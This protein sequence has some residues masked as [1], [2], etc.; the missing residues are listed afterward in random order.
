[1]YKQV[2][3]ILL[4]ILV[5]ALLQ[6]PGSAQSFTASN[7][8]RIGGWPFG[9]AEA[10][11]LDRD[12]DLAFLGSGGAVLVLDVADPK[13][14]KL[15][16]DEIRTA[17][18]V[19]DVHF[20]VLTRRLYIAAGEGGLEIWDLQ[21]PASPQRQSATEVLYFNVE[22]P[23][24]RV[25][26]EGQFA[27][28]ACAWGYVH[29]LDVSDPTNPINKGFSG[30]GGNPTIDLYVD[31]GYA[32]AAGPY[33]QRFKIM[34]DGSLNSA[35]SRHYSP[36]CSS[37][38]AVG[39][40]AY[41][42]YGGY[43]DILD[44]NALYFS[45]FSQV[46]TG[47]VANVRVV[48]NLAYVA[49]GKELLI[50]DVTSPANPVQVGYLDII[51][52]ALQIAIDGD[53]AYIAAG[54]SGLRVIDIG[55]PAVPFEAGNYE[56][57]SVTW[58][59]FVEGTYAYLAEGYEGL[60]IVDLADPEAAFVVGQYDSHGET[61]DVVLAEN[62]AYLADWDGGFRIVDVTTPA[63]P[64]ELGFLS[65]LNVWRVAVDDD[66]AYIIEGIVN[67]IY[68][69]RVID[70]TNPANPMV[71]GTLPL[72]SEVVWE[73]ALSGHHA[74]IA[75][76]NDGLRIV[77]ISDPT[78]P[79][80][81]G[82]Y[83]ANSVLD[84]CVRDDLAYVA[85]TD[86]VGGFLILDVSDPA[87]PVLK[88]KYNPNGWFHPFH[89]AV[90]GNYAYV[91]R[92]EE[93]FLFDISDPANI[94][95]IDV[96]TVPLDISRITASGPLVYLSDFWAGLQLYENLLLEGALEADV[97]EL[98]A[99]AGGESRFTLSAG[100]A[101]ANRGY[102]LL[103]SVSGTVPGTP[104]PGGAATLPL[105][106]DLFTGLVLALG[107]TSSFVDFQGNLD[108]LGIAGAMLNTQGPLPPAAVGLTMQFAY[109]LYYPWDVA[110]N[111]VGIEIKP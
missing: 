51:G 105:N 4:G 67:Q 64:V 18:Y 73:V 53:Y 33:F 65:G 36:F 106:W 87:N 93:L 79:V 2:N 56:T 68:N 103:G 19:M 88:G 21:V 3:G 59:A 107:N 39:D 111:P 30:I 83:A 13:I 99:S 81:V 25:Y 20:D 70:V 37:A 74:Y 28:V 92:F 55:N 97:G 17:G 8:T 7:L 89:L 101:H 100:T 98:A 63:N 42:G 34:P 102:L 80:Q 43:L 58:D 104:L 60:V 1:M 77:D 86:W 24:E 66:L 16:T 26:I 23:V 109:A 108:E 78:H 94:V 90:S 15:I 54:G 49:T 76:G 95:E 14:P 40:V 72:S 22:T 96:V 12:R 48:S 29:W 32:Y 61:R 46:Y 6:S 110:S 9:K 71:K 41:V 85:S 91:S 84:V 52:S 57:F 62:I 44:L 35:G 27:Y 11:D 38:Y 69:L 47:G 31:S 82:H 75:H 50:L 45:P 10:I 5:F